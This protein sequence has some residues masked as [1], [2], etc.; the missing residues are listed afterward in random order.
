LTNDR[1]N[2]YY[3]RVNKILSFVFLFIVSI[4]IV[5]S[6]LFAGGL[7]LKT[8]GSLNV[9]GTSY[10]HYWYNGSNPTLTGG[11]SPNTSLSVTVND[12]VAGT[13]LADA[14]G[15]WS[16]AVVLNEG[17]NTVVITAEGVTPYTFTLTKGELPENVGA[18]QAP[19]TPAAGNG[20]PTILLVAFSLLLI[21]SPLAFSKSLK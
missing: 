16:Q 14:T 8:I 1:V 7:Y 6:F 20:T 4:F 17:D 5:P 21:A 13:P 15:N 9:E 2:S 3:E 19:A 18:I 11:A 10:P 12:V